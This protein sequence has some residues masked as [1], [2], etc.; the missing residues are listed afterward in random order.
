GGL[1]ERAALSKSSRQHLTKV[2]QLVPG[3]HGRGGICTEGEQLLTLE[4][5]SVQ[6]S[7]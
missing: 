3:W 7:A 5:S 6:Q 2:M 4:S 1:Q